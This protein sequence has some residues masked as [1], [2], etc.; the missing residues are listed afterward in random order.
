VT[1]EHR[2]PPPD[3]NE[4]RERWR[5]RRDQILT[6]GSLGL[7]FGIAIGAAVTDLRDPTIF[8]ALVAGAFGLLGAPFVLRVDENRSGTARGKAKDD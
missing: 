4:A 1:D 3:P 7:L 8:A 2:A 5:L 6:F